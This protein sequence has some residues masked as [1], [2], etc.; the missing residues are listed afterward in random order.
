MVVQGFQ[1]E[2][3]K[4]FSEIRSQVLAEMKRL[5]SPEFLNRL[6]ES[7]VFHALDREQ[8]EKILQI[9]INEVRE[10]LSDRLISLEVSRKAIEYL[11]D[12]GYD[13]KYG[14]RPLRRVIQKQIEDPLSLDILKKKYKDGN[15]I[16]LDFKDGKLQTRKKRISSSVHNSSA[17]LVVS[18]PK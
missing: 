9:E 18:N 3:H 14:A 6:D 2:G 4:N 5:F 15:T 17:E 1:T 10:R 13:P 12:E 11:M 16:I 7:V 8:L